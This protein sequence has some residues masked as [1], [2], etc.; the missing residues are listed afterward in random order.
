MLKLADHWVWDS[1]TAY[2]GTHHHL[3]FLR[4]SRAL[5]EPDRRHLRASIGHARST[6]L[7]S[8]ELLPDALV[9]ADPDAWDDQATWTGSVVRA[10]DGSWRMF[11]TGVSRADRGLV[12]R[13]GVA[14]SDDLV[15]WE[16]LPGPVT[17][18]DPRWYETLDQGTWF[19]E[20][21]RD[22]WVL[23]DPDGDGWHMLVTARVRTGDPIGRSV[24]G[25]ARSQDLE[26]W[27]V[28][29][30]LTSPAGFGQLEVTQVEVVDGLPVLIFC[31]LSEH[32]SPERRQEWTGGGMWVVPGESLLGPWDFSR[33][34]TFDHPSLYAARL[35]QDPVLG[36]SLIGFRDTEDGQ[37][38]GEITDPLPVVRVGDRL[39]LA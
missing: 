24:V 29:P 10:D 16:R 21:W 26:H 8:W 15:V 31:C 5:L 28:G 1:W 23:R 11:Y 19:D 25:H 34:H 3:F 30:P 32:L 18:A 9:A 17:S 20:A 7:R 38:V 33:A 35:V 6:D 37:F 12:Q 14:R 22:P 13:I 27:E 2:D 39:Q 36:W 4:A